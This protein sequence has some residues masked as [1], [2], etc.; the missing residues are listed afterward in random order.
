MHMQPKIKINNKFFLQPQTIASILPHSVGYTQKPFAQSETKNVF[1][2][3]TGE[4][5][6]GN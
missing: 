2:S 6:V 4:K 1:P 5:T 3:G